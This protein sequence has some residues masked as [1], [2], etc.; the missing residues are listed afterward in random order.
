[1]ETVVRGGPRDVIA[2]A[3]Y[4]IGF[5]P[6]ESLVLVGL[7]GQRRR[8]GVV[9]RVDL[10]QPHHRSTAL[11]G[12]VR[13]LRRAGD[14]EVVVLVVSD[15]GGEPLAGGTGQ[16]LLPHWDL[17]RWLRRELPRRGIEVFDVMA[18]GAH[19]YRSYLCQ[20]PACC[21][22]DGFSLEEVASSELA[23]HMVVEGHVVA[24]SE[25]DLVADVQPDPAHQV[26]ACQ[27]SQ[28]V[29]PDRARALRRWRELIATGAAEVD[30][31]AAFLVA[32][33]DVRLR[34][35]VM[36]TLIPGSGQAPELVLS[37]EVVMPG[38]GLWDLRP[39]DDLVERGRRLLAGLVR[40]AP[41][42]ERVEA[43]SI[44]AWLAWWCNYA[45]RCRLLVDL[46]LTDCPEHRLAR[47]MF[48]VHAAGIPPTWWHE[49]G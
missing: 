34:D 18:V 16:V 21:P 5:R 48:Q 20:D 30:D 8:S 27:L 45:V 7:R 3:W 44:L 38:A 42:G 4:R 36:L 29:V 14:Q 12:V 1:M 49:P 2:L 15:A 9:V 17:V 11:R 37:G 40:V 23:A 41:P 47:L 31:P 33:R 25:Q 19:R 39:D 13:L 35:A 22:T 6:R 32:L 10:P 26:T 24:E 28:A 46:A 43:L